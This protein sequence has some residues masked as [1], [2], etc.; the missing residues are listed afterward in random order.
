[1]FPAAQLH[2]DIDNW[3]GM[4]I[5]RGYGETPQ[6]YSLHAQTGGHPD[7]AGTTGGLK[8]LEHLLGLLGLPEVQKAKTILL[9]F[10]SYDYEADWFQS[11]LDDETCAIDPA[12][13]SWIWD[14]SR[15][16]NP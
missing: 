16:C 3:K 9:S 7:D 6:T 10:P 15:Y 11:F 12:D 4:Q 8:V 1:M 14:A 13:K 5:T 2:I